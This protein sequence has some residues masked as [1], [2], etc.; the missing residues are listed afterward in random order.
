MHLAR[1]GARTWAVLGLA[2]VGF[3]AVAGALVALAGGPGGTMLGLVL[4][5]RPNFVLIVAD[6]MRYDDVEVMPTLRS[7]AQRGVSFE[8]AFATTPLCCPSRASL[9]T[10]QYARYH[11]VR[12]N[13][14]PSG[15]FDLFDDR[16]TLATWLHGGGVRTGLVGRYLNEYRSLYR[17]PGWDYWFAIWDSSEDRGLYYRYYAN[18]NGDDEFYGS[19]SEHYL[20][21]V[22]T[23]RALQFLRGE[24]ERPFLLW[25][26]PRAPHSPATPDER[27]KGVFRDLTI[28]DVPSFDE[29]DVGDKPASIRALPR[30]DQDDRTRLLRFRQRQFQ[31]LQSLDRMVADVVAALRADGRLGKTWI[32]F[33]S[34]NGL[35]V[36]EHRLPPGK[37][38]GY[39]ECIRIPLIVVPPGGLDR[40]RTESRLAA[41]IDLA[42]TV[43][44]IMGVAPG[45]P[46][47]G[48]SLL[49]LV[50]GRAGE[51]RGGIVL[52]QWASEVSDRAFTALRT[53]T[54][55][56]VAHETGEEEMYDLAA[57]P[58]ELENLAGS[59]AHADQKRGL[60]ERLRALVAEPS[61]VAAR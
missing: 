23:R 6:D 35:T 44:E 7:L 8:R 43:A 22:L 52:E 4:R 41:N 50:H 3:L 14:P 24:P 20:S 28:G 19:S 61:R 40:P 49:P 59:P 48:R 15:G 27:D 12:A 33:T 21:R 31:S 2:V 32:I 25:L 1:L 18:H 36:G 57:D 5:A 37:S 58:Y 26:T 45:G 47:D 55:K 16:S 42:P 29:E 17:P 53:E 34:D 30:L 56:Y 10:G 46:V 39:E 38:C 11:G 51:W 9:L 54:M 60:A 13:E